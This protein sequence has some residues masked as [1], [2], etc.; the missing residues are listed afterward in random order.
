M[1]S[2]S[3]LYESSWIMLKILGWGGGEGG[4]EGGAGRGEVISHAMPLK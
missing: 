3:I 1:G 2:R 4:G